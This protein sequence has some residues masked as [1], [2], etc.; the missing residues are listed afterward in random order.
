MAKQKKYVYIYLVIIKLTKCSKKL[1]VIWK[2]K[3]KLGIWIE[4]VKC[5]LLLTHSKQNRKY[6]W[7]I[8]KKELQQATLKKIYNEKDN[9]KKLI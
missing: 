5:K 4:K 7:L 1:Q 9:S 8:F 2:I 3:S 6:K